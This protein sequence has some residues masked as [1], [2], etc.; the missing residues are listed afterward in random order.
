MA[1]FWRLAVGETEAQW[2]D[3]AAGNTQGTSQRLAAR[4]G[5]SYVREGVVEASKRDSYPGAAQVFYNL[6]SHTGQTVP[7]KLL[8][9][10]RCRLQ[11]E[12]VQTSVAV[13]LRAEGKSYL[14]LHAQGWALELG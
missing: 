13:D 8:D 7:R 2:A 3:C 14:A 9:C 5:S 4:W 11:R 1:F 10:C 12:R 6:W